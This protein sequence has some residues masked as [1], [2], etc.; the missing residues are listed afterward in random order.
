MYVLPSRVHAVLVTANSAGAAGASQSP[1]RMPGPQ[2]D[3]SAVI[4]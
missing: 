2:E 1:L 4:R 3:P